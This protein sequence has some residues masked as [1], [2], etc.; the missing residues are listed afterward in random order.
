MLHKL[1]HGVF[2][3]TQKYINCIHIPNKHYVLKYNILTTIIYINPVYKINIRLIVNSV[4]ICN[5]YIV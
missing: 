3:W 2:H 1:Y 4:N 5:I